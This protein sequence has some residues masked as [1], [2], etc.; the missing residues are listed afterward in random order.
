MADIRPT[1]QDVGPWAIYTW[2][3]VT[4]ADTCLPAPIENPVAALVAQA[5]GT[6][7]GASVA[8][9]GSTDNSAFV[10]LSDVANAAVALTAAG[11]AELRYPWPYMRPAPTGGSSQSL[12]LTL[13]VL[14]S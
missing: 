2:S 13:A 7:G 1:R 10:T 9:Q 5:A 11:G 6:F 3:A 14:Q 8:V 12:T 4:E